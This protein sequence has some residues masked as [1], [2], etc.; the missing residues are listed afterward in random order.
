[1]EVLEEYVLDL[2][3]QEEEERMITIKERRITTEG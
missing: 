3:N 1:L 2:K